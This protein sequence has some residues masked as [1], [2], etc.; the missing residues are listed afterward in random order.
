MSF[1][2]PVDFRLAFGFLLS[3]THVIYFKLN[4]QNGR[5]GKDE[6][7]QLFLYLRNKSILT[8]LLVAWSTQP[9]IVANP[10]QNTELP[11]TNRTPYAYLSD[12]PIRSSLY[13]VHL[14]PSKLIRDSRRRDRMVTTRTGSWTWPTGRRALAGFPRLMLRVSS[15]QQLKGPHSKHTFKRTPSNVRPSHTNL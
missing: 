9:H 14:R 7:V 1:V 10:I 12:Q 13:T 8:R 15:S 2:F 3:S 4:A 11:G 5:G 6:D